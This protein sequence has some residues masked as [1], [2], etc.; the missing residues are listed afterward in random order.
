MRREE[1]A[2][3]RVGRS[4]GVVLVFGQNVG[5]VKGDKNIWDSV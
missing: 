2:F 3:S 4:D 1:R 5:L